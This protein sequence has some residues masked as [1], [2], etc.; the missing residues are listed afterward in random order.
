METAGSRLA[1]PT[2]RLE[3]VFRPRYVCHV[4]SQVERQKISTYR[5]GEA[6]M[7]KVG[8]RKPGWYQHALSTC[9]LPTA[10][11]TNSRGS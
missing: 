11:G 3:A 8:K 2:I 9:S 5:H 6:P 10:Q 1:R 4:Q 7:A